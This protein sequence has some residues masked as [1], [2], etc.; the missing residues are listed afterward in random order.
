[1]MKERAK[2]ATKH[3][4]KHY[5]SMD[6]A[7]ESFDT[8]IADMGPKPGTEYTLERVDGAEGY[9]PDNC[10]WATRTQQARNRTYVKLSMDKAREIRKLCGLGLRQVDVAGAFGITQA[11]VS[12]VIRSCVWIEEQ[13]K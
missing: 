13:A 3:G 4:Y 8:F 7:W 5:I 1:M 10:V 2:D 12:Q 9:G 6:P 11:H